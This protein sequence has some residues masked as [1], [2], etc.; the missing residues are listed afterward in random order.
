MLRLVGWLPVIV[1][2]FALIHAAETIYRTGVAYGFVDPARL[3]EYRL[4]TASTQD[5]VREI[6]AAI[7]ARDY[8]YAESLYRLGVSH[9]HQLPPDL[10]EAAQATWLRRAYASS[11]RAADG[12]VFG[13]V[14]SG[15]AIAGALASDLVGVG[16][17]RDF[18]VQGFNYLAGRDYDPFLL[19]FSALGLGLTA[20]TYSSLGLAATPD[21]GLSLVK[22]AY[23]TQKLSRP[24]AAYFKTSA[25]KLIDTKVL[26]TELAAVADDG[27]A[28]LG[29]LDGVASKSLNRVAAKSLLDDAAVL[30]DMRRSGG[31]GAPVAALALADGPK[32]LRKLQRVASRFGDSSHAVMKFLGKSVLRLGYAAAEIIQALISLA[33]MVMLSV[34]RLP[35][36][37]AARILLRR[38]GIA[39]LPLALARMI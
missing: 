16:D 39:A 15:E 26:R 3:A 27:L 20:A 29:R 24:L 17:V 33:A 5:Y 14:D 23:R 22:N 32:D 10:A 11:T 31:L 8:A 36:R 9:G 7:E 25:A 19:G 2:G 13:S 38:F 6:E 4:Y 30:D 18:S 37:L 28:G 34:I 12:F 21:A 35:F 1:A